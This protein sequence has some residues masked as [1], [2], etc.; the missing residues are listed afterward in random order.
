M[1]NYPQISTMPTIGSRRSQLAASLGR[2]DEFACDLHYQV[3][4]IDLH[5]LCLPDKMLTHK[6]CQISY[7]NIHFL[8]N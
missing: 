1:A 5:C 8:R 7:V 6:F 2:L 4:N 3:E